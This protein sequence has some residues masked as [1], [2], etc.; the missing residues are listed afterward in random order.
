MGK[1][2]ADL[3]HDTDPFRTFARYYEDVKGLEQLD[4][5]LYVDCMTW[6]TDDILVKVDRAS[7]YSSIDA[8]APYLDYE[9]VCY[10]AALPTP[11][12]LNGVKT[13][14]ILKEALKE[15][16]PPFVL[17]KKKSGFNAPFGLWLHSENGDEFKAFNR[18]ALKHSIVDK[19]S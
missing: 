8:R 5:H 4:Q 14:Y 3:V 7:M 11:L 15:I 12:K 2:Y 17:Q 19:T 13:K 16:L 10:A 1:Q 9:V 18:F 6:L